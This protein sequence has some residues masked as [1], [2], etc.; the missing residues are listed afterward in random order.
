MKITKS[1]LRQIIKE[2]VEKVIDETA[3]MYGMRVDPESDEALVLT[4]LHDESDI[5]GMP[6]Q[7]LLQS[8]PLDQDDAL[9]N[10]GELKRMGLIDAAGEGL[11]EPHEIMYALTGDGEA[12]A[13][14]LKSSPDSHY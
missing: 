4:V 12:E 2:E 11:L 13:L 1:R 3:S 14:S 5:G 9:L 6:L 10:L 7:D 8:L